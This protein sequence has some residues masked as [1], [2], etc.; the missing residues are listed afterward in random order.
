MSL[1]LIVLFLYMNG[2]KLSVLG[3][4]GQ[5]Y[6]AFTS[7]GAPVD[8][9]QKGMLLVSIRAGG[10]FAK[11][12]LYVIEHSDSST[13]AVILNKPLKRK[14]GQNEDG[15]SLTLSIRSG[16]PLR[17]DSFCIHNIDGALGSERL[18]QGQAVYFTR[19]VDIS[20]DT[21]KTTKQVGAS[22][23]IFQGF[24]R[25][26][27][28]Q[29]E[30]EVRRGA[31]GWIKPEHVRPEDVLEM[32]HTV[33]GETWDRMVNSPHLQVFEGYQRATNNGFHVSALSV[34]HFI[35]GLADLR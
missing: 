12:I 24:A 15:S 9:L 19:S 11:S 1:P 7:F 4:P 35:R 31:W 13:L 29:L 20:L 21:L 22:M 27:S 6:L 2:I 16:G 18:L 28:H 23:A 32:D 10:P 14:Q 34:A 25:W 17:Q 33:L 3:S 30:G 8:G 5:Y 26:G